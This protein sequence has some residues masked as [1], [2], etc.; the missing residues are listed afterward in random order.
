MKLKFIENT[1]FVD[2]N[3]CMQHLIW[4][5]QQNKQKKEKSKRMVLAYLQMMGTK[6]DNR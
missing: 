6:L 3:K 1:Y 4:V 5:E 2:D